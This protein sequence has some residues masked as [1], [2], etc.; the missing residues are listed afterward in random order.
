MALFETNFDMNLVYDNSSLSASVNAVLRSADYDASVGFRPLTLEQANWLRAFA[1]INEGRYSSDFIEEIRMGFNA[2]VSLDDMKS[3][4][5]VFG[6]DVSPTK[7]RIAL[8][9]TLTSNGHSIEEGVSILTPDLSGGEDYALREQ[10]LREIIDADIIFGGRTKENALALQ[11]FF[12]DYAVNLRKYKD[13]MKNNSIV[14]FQLREEKAKDVEAMFATKEGREQIESLL[15]TCMSRDDM[16]DYYKQVAMRCKEELELILEPLDKERSMVD[17][18]ALGADDFVLVEAKGRLSVGS[19]KKTL[20]TDSYVLFTSVENEGK[21]VVCHDSGSVLEMDKESFPDWLEKI[22]NRRDE[23]TLNNHL[24]L[25]ERITDFYSRNGENVFCFDVTNK[26]LPYLKNMDADTFETLKKSGLE[27]FAKEQKDRTLEMKYMGNDTWGRKVFECQN[28]HTLYKDISI[29]SVTAF[30]DYK[31][32]LYTCDNRFEGE[33]DCPLHM[34][35]Y[36]FSY[37]A[38]LENVYVM[39][40]DTVV[41]ENAVVFLK[42]NYYL[43]NAVEGKETDSLVYK[44]TGE[45]GKEVTFASQEKVMEGFDVFERLDPNEEW[46]MK[47]LSNRNKEPVTVQMSL[48]FSDFGKHSEE[49]IGHIEGTDVE[50]SIVYMDEEFGREGYAVVQMQYDSVENIAYKDMDGKPYYL[51]EY[52]VLKEMNPLL[53]KTCDVITPVTWSQTKELPVKVD[54]YERQFVQ[55]AKEALEAVGYSDTVIDDLVH[56]NMSQMELETV[57][58]VLQDVLID[59]ATSEEKTLTFTEQEKIGL[60]LTMI[61]NMNH[62]KNGGGIEKASPIAPKKNEP[63]KKQEKTSPAK[64]N[65]SKT[66]KN[67]FE[68]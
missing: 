22:K 59:N 67:G 21:I 62:E 61:S 42:E 4:L 58:S 54:L 57:G 17:I 1:V 33:P 65:K 41:Q 30:A 32:D 5:G 34:D 51:S 28:N 20:Y 38:S 29:H 55:G 48:N 45:N 36:S 68:H 52:D 47:L 2:K 60:L 3:A 43:C 49:A 23:V 13:Y 9:N 8:L 39:A 25:S 46:D 14:Y 10:Q 6:E 31:P 53:N 24:S 66:Q 26:V 19:A 7:W 11:I 56:E 16:S 27:A 44:V 18:K 37:N 50:V 40:K 64:E 15:N 12:I 63:V 35:K